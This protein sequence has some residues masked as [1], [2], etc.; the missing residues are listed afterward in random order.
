MKQGLIN[1]GSL[2]FQMSGIGLATYKNMGEL[3]LNVQYIFFLF[4][5][6]NDCG[7]F[8]LAIIIWSLSRRLIDMLTE[9][10]LLVQFRI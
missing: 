4:Y 2:H 9:V 5:C 7:I 8:R 6:L 1:F 10:F 3:E